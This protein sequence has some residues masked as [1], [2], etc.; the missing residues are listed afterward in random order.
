V[1]DKEKLPRPEPYYF[2]SR[3]RL[4]ID[5]NDRLRGYPVEH[6]D[7]VKGRKQQEELKK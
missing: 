5:I 6:A 3:E 7:Y 1:K 4:I 2:K